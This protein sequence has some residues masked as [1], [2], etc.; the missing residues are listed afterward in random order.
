MLRKQPKHP[1]DEMTA[2]LRASLAQQ[3]PRPV[4]AALIGLGLLVVL[5]AALVWWFYPR[6]ELPPPLVTAF[7]QMALP[8]EAVTLRARLEPADADADSPHLQGL[9][10]FFETGLLGEIQVIGRAATDAHGE[11]SVAWQP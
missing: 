10:L 5:G 4:K 11:A 6:A 7:D 1:D 2:W 9:D 3:R 8:G